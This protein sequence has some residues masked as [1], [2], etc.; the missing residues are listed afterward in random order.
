MLRELCGNFTWLIKTTTS[1][2]LSCYSSTWR[3]AKETRRP[4][5][6]KLLTLRCGKILPLRVFDK[7]FRLSLLFKETRLSSKSSLLSTT[8]KILKESL[9]STLFLE[10]RKVR[11]ACPQTTSIWTTV[12]IL[13]GG[14]RDIESK[15]VLKTARIRSVQR[16]IIRLEAL[17]SL[18]Q[19]Y[20]R[21]KLS[22]A[23]EM[24]TRDQS[25]YSGRGR[26]ML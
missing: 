9:P 4:S 1:V 22:R 18:N 6:S 11:V 2:W 24:S 21:R 15:R 5:L 20:H 14:S 25:H 26:H 3:T 10:T 17:L 19:A 23:S 16:S 8:A 7:N 13:R 12:T